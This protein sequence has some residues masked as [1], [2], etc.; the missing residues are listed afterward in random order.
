MCRR[1]VEE[2][3]YLR[4][5]WHCYRILE[6]QAD[7]MVGKAAFFRFLTLLG[8]NSASHVNLTFTRCCKQRSRQ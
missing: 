8:G 6:N 5:F 3:V 2:D 4:A 7:E 1:P